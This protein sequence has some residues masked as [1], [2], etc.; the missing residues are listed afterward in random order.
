MDIHYRLER[1]VAMD[2]HLQVEGFTVLL[3]L[4]GEGKSTL[5]KAIAGLLPAS[6]T[7]FGGLPA[8]QRPIGYLPQGY[9]LFPHLRAWE[10]VAFPLPPGTDRRREA[11]DLLA[12]MGLA[13]WAERYPATLSGGQRQR[14]ALAR[15]LARRP[16]LLLLDEPTS[17]LDM[18]TRDEILEDL[19]AEMRQLQIPV[20]AVTHDP[21]LATMA[22]RMAILAGGVIVQEGT[23]REL[24]AEPTNEAVARLVGF[25]NI[26]P[27][28]VALASSTGVW[29]SGPGW[30]LQATPRPWARPGMVVA[31]GIRSEEVEIQEAA[32]GGENTLC[33]QVAER[34]DEGLALR[35]KLRGALSLDVLLPRLRQRDGGIID[36]SGSLPVYVAPGHVHLF[37]PQGAMG[38]A[39]G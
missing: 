10:N 35:L 13:D 21:H 26:F 16:Q 9:G 33:L 36:P 27:A 4:S 11:M 24:F 14:V 39:P 38:V 2:V 20:L 15:A 3:G 31:V 1:P 5:L 23:P 6:G 18:A 22:D 12:R 28:T 32:T 7:P 29:V 8:Q 25:R 37:P 17:A 34:R 30:R 19:I